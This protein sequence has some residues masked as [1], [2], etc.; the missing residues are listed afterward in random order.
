M[1][2]LVLPRLAAVASGANTAAERIRDCGA[3]QQ[4][5]RA[6]GRGPPVPSG[7]CAEGYEFAGFDLTQNAALSLLGHGA[8][9]ARHPGRIHGKEH[10][11]QK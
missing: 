9:I 4:L 10:R 5:A 8:P 2:R 6:V 7:E 1:D 11:W 3:C